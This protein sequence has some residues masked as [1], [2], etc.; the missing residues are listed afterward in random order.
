MP[1]PATGWSKRRP[2]RAG[3][4]TNALYVAPVPLLFTGWG[5]GPAGLALDL[6]AFFV[7]IAAAH[8]TREGI[9]AEMAYE[10]RAAARRPALPR[11]LLGAAL[12]GAG[13]AL[14]GL[15]A[16]GGAIVL[17]GLG[18][19]L[20]VGAFGI[21]PLRNKRPEG[22]EAWQS[23]RAADAID[24]AE[25]HL[26]EM[27]RQIERTGDRP[28]LA[29]VEQFAA[30]ARGLFRKVERDPRDLPKARAWLGVYLRGARD[31][32]AKYADLAQDGAGPEARAEF[33][34]LLDDLE[35]GFARRTDAML[36]DDRSD[37]DVEIEVLRDRLRR[38]DLAPA[39]RSE[40]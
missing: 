37:L 11:K 16:V 39:A 29:R 14:A 7:L 33:V 28:L 6:A 21:D 5:A 34:A 32:A 18:I 22:A 40:V 23:E 25:A 17:A 38:D 24:L 8:S 13:L 20:H 9:R 19:A 35:Q 36:L 31:A 10:E 1:G 3:A 4:R 26:A 27:R 12:T 2:I 15:P 30:T